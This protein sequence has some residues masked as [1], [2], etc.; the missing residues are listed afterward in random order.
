MRLA[1]TA[2]PL[3]RNEQVWPAGVEPAIS[4]AQNRRGGHLPYSQ[5]V[6]FAV[7]YPLAR[8]PHAQTPEG[9]RFAVAAAAT[10]GPLVPR[11]RP[12]RRPGSRRPWNRTTLHRRIRAALAQ[13]AR[14]RCFPAQIGIRLRGL[15]IAQIPEA[16]R[17]ATGSPLQDGISMG[18]RQGIAPCSPGS[19]PGGSLQ[20]LRRSLAGRIRTPVRHGRSVVLP[21]E[22]RRDSALDGN[23]TRLTRETTGPHV[24]DASESVEYP[25][26]DSNPRLRFER[27]AS[28]TV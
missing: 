12:W 20:A 9:A 18:R 1:R 13:P 26:R 27:P 11:T 6:S 15:P 8:I 7:R 25:E 14:R 24:P 19:Q 10:H 17:F 4:G 5:A 2:S 16:G 21:T 23:R 3:P 22:L 28:S